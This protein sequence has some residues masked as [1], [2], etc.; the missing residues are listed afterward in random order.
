MKDPTL[1]NVNQNSLWF[2]NRVAYDHAYAGVAY[3]PE[4]GKRL[5]EILGTYYLFQVSVNKCN[6]FDDTC[7]INCSI[8]NTLF[9]HIFC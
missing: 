5:G 7:Y 1:R 8:I 9:S 3:A 4:E 2:Y 6:I